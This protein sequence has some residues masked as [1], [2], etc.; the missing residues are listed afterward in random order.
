MIVSVAATIIMVMM[1]RIAL[2]DPVVAAVVV[3]EFT[4]A[5]IEF[6]FTIVIM[7]VTAVV[8]FRSFAMIRKCSRG[9][10]V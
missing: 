6:T 7:I 2:T 9:L 3:N 10:Q 5:T 1:V 4:I 8:R